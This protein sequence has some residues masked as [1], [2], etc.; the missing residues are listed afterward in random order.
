[1]HRR[2]D[3]LGIF[4]PLNYQG[5]PF[6]LFSPKIEEPQSEN[7]EEPFENPLDDAQEHIFSSS[8]ESLHLNNLFLE[9]EYQ[10]DLIAIPA[11]ITR[12]SS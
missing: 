6:D 2:R 1:M 3:H 11:T 8:F 10:D 12:P 7:E 4:L 9:H 5:K